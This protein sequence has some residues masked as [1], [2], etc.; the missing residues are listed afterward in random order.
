MSRLLICR[1]CGSR[2]TETLAANELEL[3]NV[4]LLERRCARC[5]TTTKW[6]MAMDYRRAERRR[7]DRRSKQRRTAKERR[8]RQRRVMMRRA[9]RK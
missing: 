7:E 8:A 9:P 4:G 6:G 1:A 3:V 2:L 5:G